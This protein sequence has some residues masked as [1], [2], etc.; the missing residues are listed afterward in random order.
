MKIKPILDFLSVLRE[1]NN[2][3]WMETNKSWFHE[4][5]SDFSEIVN[6]L[7]GEIVGF[8]PSVEGLVPKDCIFRLNRDIRF[9]K[10]KSLYKTHF[11]AYIAEGGRK[12]ENAGY[13]FHLEPGDNSL[14]AG[15]MYIPSPE[16][17]KKIRQEID[18]NPSELKKIVSDPS[19]RDYFGKVQG[20]QLKTTPKGYTPDH[21]NIE[22]LKLKSY[23]AM[24]PVSDAIALSP[25]FPDKAVLVFKAMKP[26][27]EFL[28]TAVS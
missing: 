14:L 11:G 19:F 9:S 25:G 16:M 15:G 26:F 22:F 6:F 21:P 4:V 28:N 5:R 23:M 1:N 10:D 13:Y 2:R 12:S 24:H 17:I 20:E 8:D 7:I 3:E 18:Y 27:N